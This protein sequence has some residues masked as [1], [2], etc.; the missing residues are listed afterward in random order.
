MAKSYAERLWNILWIRTTSM[1]QC[2]AQAAEIAPCT[3]FRHCGVRPLATRYR[4]I[5][6]LLHA[7]AV[8]SESR[9]EL[10]HK[11]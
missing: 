9:I 6:K 5:S 4:S 7:A 1:S 8:A 2:G 10:V 11:R 3:L